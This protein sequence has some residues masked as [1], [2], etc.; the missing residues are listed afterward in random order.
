MTNS[1]YIVPNDWES[2]R[3][4]LSLLEREWDPKT[5]EMLE[6][7]GVGQGWRCF[8]LGAGGG[9]M[10][11]W[12]CRRVGTEGRVVAMDFNTQFVDALD[13]PQL[14]VRDADIADAELE[15]GAY[16]LLYTR[17]TLMHIAERDAVLR[18]LYDAVRPGGWLAVAEPDW[19]T[20]IPD[21]DSAAE[22]IERSDGETRFREAV[23]PQV[24]A[25]DSYGRRLY[26]AMES[27]GLESLDVEGWARPFHGRS[28]VAE[29]W[30][31]TSL[32]AQQRLIES[33]TK[34]AAEVIDSLAHWR[35]SDFIFWNVLFVLASGRKPAV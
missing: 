21:P 7:T 19:I 16:D 23:L 31:I 30:R 4:R 32:Q 10:T 22:M 9:S 1:E 25:S 33:G 27:L 28:D 18:K 6:R 8:D 2:A 34:T 35:D 5:I 20:R 17:A 14:E 29:F 12:L 3:Q 15:E 26:R 24:G 11:E 13:Y